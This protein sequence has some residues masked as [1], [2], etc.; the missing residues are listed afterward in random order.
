M[1]LCGL[2]LVLVMQSS[3]LWRALIIVPISLLLIYGFAIISISGLFL[4][5]YIMVFIG[6]L[7]IFL[8]SV[9]SI[10][11]QEQNFGRD[12]FKASLFVS[13]LT[14]RL[15]EL[16]R[17]TLNSSRV[18]LT[19]W[20]ETQSYYTVIYVLILILALLVIRGFFIKYKG[21]IRYV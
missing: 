19:F 13:L 9:A 5:V 16:K 3:S 12:I 8:V 4:V 7:L 20:L 17:A 11:S 14:P 18:L 6:G 10:M 1:V 15:L 2:I 21:L